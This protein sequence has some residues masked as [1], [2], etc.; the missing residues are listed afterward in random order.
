MHIRDSEIDLNV[1]RQRCTR[2]DSVSDMQSMVEMFDDYGEHVLCS[3]HS[4]TP[5]IERESSADLALS[6]TT[7]RDMPCST[8]TRRHSLGPQATERA[9]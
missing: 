3:V 2:C 4:G 5:Y 6:G 1:R 9:I 8:H 7:E